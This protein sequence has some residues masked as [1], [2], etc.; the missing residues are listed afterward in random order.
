[1]AFHEDPLDSPSLVPDRVVLQ[2]I[3]SRVRRM[4]STENARIK[5]SRIR[6]WTQRVQHAALKNAKILFKM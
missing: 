5:K 6:A 4:H 2:R 1:M 3:L